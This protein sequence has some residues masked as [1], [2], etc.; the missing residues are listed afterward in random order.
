VR[1]KTGAGRSRGGYL[2]RLL[3]TLAR[4]AGIAERVHA[5]GLR[6]TRAAELREEEVDI[7]VIS[8]QLGAL[9]H[10]DDGAAYTTLRCAR[11]LRRLRR[12]A[13]ARR[14]AAVRFSR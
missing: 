11:S 1:L 6:Q 12:D 13:G 10:L 4:R 9:G 8:K 3:P 2:R 14:M 7:G 5:H